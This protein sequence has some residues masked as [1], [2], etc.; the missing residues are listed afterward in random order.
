MKTLVAYILLLVL[1][2]SAVAES[3]ISFPIVADEVDSYNDGNDTLF[4]YNKE[5]VGETPE[6]DGS[7]LA[8][9]AEEQAGSL[10]ANGTL[11]QSSTGI[12]AEEEPDDSTLA[13]PYRLPLIKRVFVWADAITNFFMGCDTTYVTPQKYEFTAQMELSY[14][15]DYYRMTSS[16][17]GHTQSMVLQ[18]GNPLVL[19]AYVYWSIFGYGHSINLGDIG[20]PQGQTNG[21]GYRN[22]F[23]LNTARIIA[24]VYTFKSGKSARF[25]SISGVDLA[26]QDRTFTGLN[27]KCVGVD[28]Q[29][30]FNHRRYSWPAAFGENAVQRRSQGSRKLGFSYNHSSISFNKD[31][32]SDYILERIDTTLLF[33]HVDYNDYA[34]SVGYGYNWAFRKNCIWAVSILPSIGYRQSNITEQDRDHA[35]LRRISTDVFFRTSLFWNNTKYFA[36]FVVDLHTYAYRQHRFSLTNTYGTVKFIVGFDFLR[37]RG[38]KK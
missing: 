21:T 3:A 35:I 14:W 30:I 10:S 33:N 32:L 15:H 4:I 1:P 2:L 25:T 29:Y 6:T 7:M 38:A 20:K 36:G 24:E 37:K 11:P 26:G 16:E 9:N 34:V 19:G 12:Q 17:S 27:S 5:R 22:S 23:V 18:S 31:E 8:S 13:L 28:A